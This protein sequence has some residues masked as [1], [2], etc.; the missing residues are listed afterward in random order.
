MGSGCGGPAGCPGEQ[1][2]VAFLCFSAAL[3]HPAAWGVW[4][5]KEL[6]LWVTC[7]CALAP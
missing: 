4:E 3:V 2:P 6:S 5:T 7:V 1:T